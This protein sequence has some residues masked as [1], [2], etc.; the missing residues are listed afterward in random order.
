MFWE[1]ME[2]H[3]K[4]PRQITGILFNINNC[5]YRPGQKMDDYPLMQPVKKEGCLG[6]Q[7]IIIIALIVATPLV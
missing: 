4:N 7:C 2:T 3:W 5:S 1:N 6:C